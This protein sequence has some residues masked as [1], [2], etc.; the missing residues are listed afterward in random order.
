MRSYPLQCVHVG[1]D[2]DTAEFFMVVENG[3]L[4]LDYVFGEL[5]K[6]CF[7]WQ[8]E[9]EFHEVLIPDPV[10]DGFRRTHQVFS[11]ILPHIV[12]K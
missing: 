9:H 10:D 2:N 3:C 1:N 5:N 7:F 4:L 6:S 12:G 8:F 11:K